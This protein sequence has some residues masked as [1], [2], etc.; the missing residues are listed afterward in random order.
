MFKF[1]FILL[2]LV[3]SSYAT[4]QSIK[5]QKNL[6]D[7][8]KFYYLAEKEADF[9]ENKKAILHFQESYKSSYLA[10]NSC[11][12]ENNYDFNHIYNYIIA[13]ENKIQKIKEDMLEFSLIK[14]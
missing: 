11:E 3:T 6:I 9:Q 13:T 12:D 2:L 4:S 8:T 1:L 7:M 14:N 10:L 5:C